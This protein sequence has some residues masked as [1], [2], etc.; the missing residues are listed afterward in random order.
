MARRLDNHAARMT[1]LKAAASQTEDIAT[2]V[3]A[4]PEADAFTIAIE[5]AVSPD[6]KAYALWASGERKSV[7]HDD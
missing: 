2:R 3:A 4:L 6:G 5:E 1:A 7:A